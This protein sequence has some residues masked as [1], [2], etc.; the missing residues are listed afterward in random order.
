MLN[1]DYLTLF[2]PVSFT[3]LFNVDARG[4]RT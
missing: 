4:K 1:I 3:F 2:L